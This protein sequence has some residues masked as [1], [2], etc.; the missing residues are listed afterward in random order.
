MALRVG[1]AIVDITPPAGLQ[2]AGFGARTEPAKGAHDALT[3]RA[4]AVNDTALVVA[5][6]IGIDQELSRRVRDA[7]VLPAG[8]VVITALHNHG[9]PAVERGPGGLPADAD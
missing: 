9:G 2:M 1:P 3:V 8:R 5:D 4:I 6:I 7:C